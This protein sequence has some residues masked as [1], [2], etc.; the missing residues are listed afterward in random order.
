MKI[1]ATVHVF[2]PEFWPQLARCLGN[3]GAPCDVV[4]TLPEGAPFADD[5]RRDFPAARILPCEN[6][7]FDVW[8]FLRALGEAGLDG[9][10]HVLKL[11]TKRDV[12]TDPPTFFNDFDYEGPRWRDALLSFVADGTSFEKCRALFAR[13]PSVAMVAGRD[14]IVRRRDVEHPD[15]RRTFDEALAYAA[16]EFGIRP[17]RPEFVAGTMFMARADVF[18]PFLGRF[19]AADFAP[20]AKDDRVVTRAH[21]LERALGFAACA[22]GRIADPDD[23]MRLRHLRS[24]AARAAKAVRRFLL[25]TKTT[26][27]GARITKI[28]RI[29][30]WHSRKERQ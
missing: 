26:R 1:L 24:D 27:S 16:D 20:S 17:A 30:V 11:H 5:I 7:G 25:Q 18:R 13:D 22:A 8:P 29:P 2:Y 4:A 3:V 15:V 23:S 9:Y 19:S 28:C 6:R 21:L 12:H 14:V 10:T